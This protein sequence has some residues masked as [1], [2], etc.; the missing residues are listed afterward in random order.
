MTTGRINQVTI[1]RRG[2][3]PARLSAPERCS[4]LLVG[5]RGCAARSTIGRANS[6]TGGSPLSP[7]EFPRASVH[8]TAPAN[9]PCGLGAPGGGRSAGLLPL[10][11]QPSRGYLPLLGDRFSQ[12]PSF[13][14]AHPTAAGDELPLQPGNPSTPYR[15][16]GRFREGRLPL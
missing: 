11:C 12:R 10:R 14:R 15:R 9:G 7:S 3:P 16:S 5:T 4:K 1:V 13:H 8:R 6:A 2:W